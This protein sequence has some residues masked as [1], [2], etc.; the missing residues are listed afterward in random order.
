[1][2]VE[3]TPKG[4]LVRRLREVEEKFQ[5][6]DDKRIKFVELAGTKVVNLLEKKIHLKKIVR[7]RSVNLV[8]IWLKMVQKN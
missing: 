5:I 6:A 3:P 2:F 4:E 1:M 7:K 8:R